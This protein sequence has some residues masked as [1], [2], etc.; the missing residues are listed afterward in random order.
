MPG[1]TRVHEVAKE[2]GQTSQTILM[3]LKENGEFVKSASSTLEGPVVRKIRA[4]FALAATAQAGTDVTQQDQPSGPQP[5]PVPVGPP[6]A[7]PLPPG[8][9]SAPRPPRPVAA[10]RPPSDGRPELRYNVDRLASWDDAVEL[11]RQARAAL[12]DNHR[13][14][15][16]CSRTAH[17][18]PN[19]CVPAA[20]V[21]QSYRT[22]GLDVI[23]D[24]EASYIR[25]A[26]L[27]NPVEASGHNLQNH[28]VFSRVWAYFDPEQ[29][30]ALTR[31]IVQTLERRVECETGVLDALSLCLYE[32]L[33]NVFEHSQASAGF[34]MAQIHR[35]NAQLTLCIVDNGI[36]ARESFRG[37]KYRPPSDFDALTLAIQSGVS[38]TGDKR[39]N[40][41]YFLHETAQQNGGRLVLK[42]GQGNLKLEHGG[43][44]GDNTSTSPFPDRRAG[45]VIDW[46][47]ELAAA[48]SLKSAL[49]L[50][51]PNLDFES[52]QDDLGQVVV[53]IGD[54]EAGTGSRTAA[55]QLRAYLTN[56]LNQGATAV[57]LDFTGVAV[58]S[59][60]FADEVIGKLAEEL[61]PMRFFQRFQMRNMTPLIE[62]LL[63]RAIKLRLSTDP[64][65][66]I[67]RD[68]GRRPRDR[69][70]TRGGFRTQ[71]PGYEKP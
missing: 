62:G 27:R 33:D 22:A 39:G 30:S 25:T 28:D 19:G 18:Y 52:R 2:V 7:R 60:S 43:V 29:A 20:A 51:M 24:G 14:V 65:P 69:T 17:V 55:A 67:E 44:R 3:W 45:F 49:G 6:A 8:P 40:G 31:R 34:I 35:Q 57:L 42:S 32:A 12:H 58:V 16:D 9:A 54:H 37:S 21:I 50:S 59:A 36:G 1:K 61:G 64:P 5:V 71:T 46:Q 56:Q 13:L 53:P 38:R 48:V 41:L 70:R 26:A 66:P 4:A 23:F 11:S 63:D 15:L 68:A 47:V 10:R